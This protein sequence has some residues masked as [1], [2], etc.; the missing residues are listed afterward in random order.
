MAIAQAPA[1]TV[2]ERA[3]PIL[4]L[5]EDVLHL[6]SPLRPSVR[7]RVR[8]AND[9]AIRTLRHL[10]AEDETLLRPENV[11][12]ICNAVAHR[13]GVKP[14][15]MLTM[16]QIGEQLT[17]EFAAA[18]M[19]SHVRMRLIASAVHLERRRAAAEPT[20]R[21]SGDQ[22]PDPRVEHVA[23]A[24]VVLAVLAI[25]GGAVMLAMGRTTWGLELA[26]AA[27][28]LV[29]IARAA[30]AISADRRASAIYAHREAAGA[31]VPDIDLRTPDA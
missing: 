6:D 17:L 16:R 26:I 4:D 20:R 13:H 30:L 27:T 8:A 5:F 2:V 21:R 22:R 19:P 31:H 25:V 28:S 14:R 3:G 23:L 18:L 10:A 15:F 1:E 7:R 9:E 11:R 12:T 24:Q 29:V